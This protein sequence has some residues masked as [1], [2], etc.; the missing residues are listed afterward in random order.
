[1]EGWR[2]EEVRM[3]RTRNW[4]R[5]VRSPLSSSSQNIA[6]IFITAP[7]IAIIILAVTSEKLNK[8]LN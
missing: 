8:M 6:V 3:R 5:G 2:R 1:M 7:I 4:R